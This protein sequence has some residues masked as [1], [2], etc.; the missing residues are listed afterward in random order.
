M[1]WKVGWTVLI[2][3]MNLTS[4]WRNYLISITVRDEAGVSGDACS[5]V[6][7]DSFGQLRLPQG[8]E[9]VI[10]MLSGV[11]VF[12]GV[13]DVP[14]SKGS[15]SGGCILAINATGFDTAGKAKEPLAFHIDDATLKDFL[16][17]A[18]ELA[19][20]EITV[21]EDLGA[22]EKDYWAADNESFLALGERLAR[23][24]GATFKLRGK[25]A[26]FAKKGAAAMIPVLAMP[27][28]LL[29]WEIAPR[30]PRKLFKAGRARYFNRKSGEI[31]EIEV[32][33]EAP[34][35][36]AKNVVRPALGDEAEAEATLDARKR[37]SERE[38]GGGAVTLTMAPAAF[39][40]GL[41]MVA[42][43]RPG[44][45]GTYRIES[46]EHRADR[47]GGATTRLTLKLRE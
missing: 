37:E 47:N 19:E 7:D 17:K 31:E 43:T 12:E 22:I 3:G 14:R 46:V 32:D 45:D 34:T 23:Q 35:A 42:G 6:A 41:C 25:K 40:E 20:F 10:V 36:E 21:D 8:G 30:D 27:S 28:N 4:V 26:V 9:A 1:N 39:A 13:V 15:R 24:F 29:D 38:A 2:G 44:I 16:T 5:L 11:K 33:F 18:A